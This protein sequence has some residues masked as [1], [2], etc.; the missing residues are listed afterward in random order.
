MVVFYTLN[1]TPNDLTN[2]G[3]HSCYL[4]KVL[5]KSDIFSMIP[6]T[7]ILLMTFE[8]REQVYK[9]QNISRQTVN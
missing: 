6:D 8:F 1:A 2:M 5:R 4:R 9:E 3:M 7:Y